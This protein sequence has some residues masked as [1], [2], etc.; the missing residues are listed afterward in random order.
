MP[1]STCSSGDCEFATENRG[2]CA[3]HYRELMKQLY[4]C[5]IDGC[6]NWGQYK[7]TRYCQTHQSRLKKHG[8]PHVT[9]KGKAH[10]VQHTEDGLRICKKCAEPKPLTEFHKDSGNPDGYRAQC[11]PCR[12]GYMAGYYSDNQDARKAYEQDRRT[13]N[14]DH[15]R[16]LDMARYERHREKRIALATE[17]VH[18]RRARM[19][20]VES[21]PGVN[22]ES[23]RKRDGDACCYC[24][25]VM[26]FERA[27]GRVF[28]GGHATVEHIIP[29]S[30]GGGHLMSNAKLACRSCNL[31]KNS[32]KLDEWSPTTAAVA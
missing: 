2:L 10:A 24:G 5:V 3:S 15:M 20:T 19:K 26:D 32:K 14:A 21:E 9:M 6:S 16:A 13:N 31:R 30:R 4:P 27:V 11:K 23:L 18:V 12:N 28:H 29:I 17:A 25:I 1:K 8:D 22:R 7:A